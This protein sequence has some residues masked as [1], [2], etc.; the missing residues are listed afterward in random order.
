MSDECP[1]CKL[2]GGPR[3]ATKVAGGPGANS[4]RLIRLRWRRAS[5][6]H[7]EGSVA[8]DDESR[9]PQPGRDSGRPGVVLERPGEKLCS[10]AEETRPKA[11]ACDEEEKKNVANAKRR[12]RG[13]ERRVPTQL[14][15]YSVQACTCSACYLVGTLLRVIRSRRLGPRRWCTGGNLPDMGHSVDWTSKTSPEWC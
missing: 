2:P 9:S 15:A 12:T 13:G 3:A 7:V 5:R 10:G 6:R 4:Q 1:R 11:R 8:L 14:P